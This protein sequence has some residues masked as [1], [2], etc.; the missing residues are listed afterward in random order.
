MSRFAAARVARLATADAAGTPHLVPITFVVTEDVIWFAV[1]DKPKRSRE[2][3]RLDNIRTN[4]AVSVLVDHY[5]DDWSKLWWERADGTAEVI[6]DGPV[7][8]LAE[9]YPHYRD[10]PPAGPF[11]KI[12]VQRWSAW[13]AASPPTGGVTRS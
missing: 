7:D 10:R 8:L 9:K 6:A 3:R 5:E 2:L 13:E 12:T 11:V 4:P 1:D